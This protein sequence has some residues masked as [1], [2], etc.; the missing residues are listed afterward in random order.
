MRWSRRRLRGY[1]LSATPRCGSNFFG[2][3]LASTGVLGDP[4]EYLNAVGRRQ[5][6]DDPDYPDDPGEQ[7]ARVVTTGRTSNGVYGVKIHPFQL[8]AMPADLDL[9]TELPDVH[10]VRMV[11]E[12]R[13]GQALSWSRATRSGRFRAGEPGYGAVEYDRD[14][15]TESLRFIDHEN[16]SWDRLLA[17]RGGPTITVSYEEVLLDPQSA[18]D[19]VAALMRVRR[20]TIDLDLVTVR[21]QRDE[22]SDEWRRRYV[23]GN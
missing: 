22:S 10:V 12:D 5:Y 7:L 17:D 8:A 21:V 18:V 13:L 16:A 11:R 4:R 20:A 23:T 2:Q 9:W 1:V 6:D 3:L 19:R 14:H 15:V